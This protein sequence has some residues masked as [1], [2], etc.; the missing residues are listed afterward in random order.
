M[1]S[2]ALCELNSTLIFFSCVPSVPPS[3]EKLKEPERRHD[4]CIEFTV[5][6]SPHP[7]LRWFHEDKV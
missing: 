4:T 7:S 3:I 6:G 2:K 1:T 5:R